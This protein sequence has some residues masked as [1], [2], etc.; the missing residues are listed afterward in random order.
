MTP[1]PTIEDVEAMFD[2]AG[3]P[4]RDGRRRFLIQ[5][6]LSP[7]KITAEELR[8]QVDPDAPAAR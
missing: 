1:K 2:A 4:D 6:L 5:Q 3:F 8:P 7:G